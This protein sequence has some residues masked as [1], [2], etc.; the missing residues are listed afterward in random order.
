MAQEHSAPAVEGASKKVAA[1]SIGVVDLVKALEAYPKRIKMEQEFRKLQ[2]NYLSQL[3]EID[4][5]MKAVGCYRSQFQNN[6]V[7]EM[8]KTLCGYFGGRIGTRY[9]EP[10]FSHEVL[11]FGGID[12]LV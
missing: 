11:G 8:V 12:Q 10:F 4:T 2:E 1:V 7:P 9:A 6:D 3:R 5:K